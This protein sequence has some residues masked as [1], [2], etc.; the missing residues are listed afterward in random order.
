MAEA[1]ERLRVIQAEVD[2]LRVEVR[3]DPAEE[4][5]GRVFTGVFE[6]LELVELTEHGNAWRSYVIVFSTFFLNLKEVELVDHAI[7]VFGLLLK[8]LVKVASSFTEVDHVQVSCLVFFLD[9][10][11]L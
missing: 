6:R 3:V 11:T 5:I 4:R 8:Y 2:H 10:S 7:L 1:E 9:V